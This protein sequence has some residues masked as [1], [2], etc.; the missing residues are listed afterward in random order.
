[1]DAFQLIIILSMKCRVSEVF[2]LQEIAFCRKCQ[3]Y[4]GKGPCINYGG[5]GATKREGGGSDLA[6][7]RG[8]GEG[9]TCFEVVLTQELEVLAIL[10]GGAKIVRPIKGG[11]GHK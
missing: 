5:G 2:I 8:G 7:L 9:T 1:M 11:G 4:I 10:K 3:I 6:M